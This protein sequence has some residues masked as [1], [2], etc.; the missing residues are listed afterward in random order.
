MNYD[1]GRLTL[2]ILGLCNPLL[3]ITAQVD[4]EFLKKYNLKANDA[5][6]ARDEHLHLCQDMVSSYSVQYTAGGAAQNVM[7]VISGILKR[8]GLK[9]RVMFTGCIGK[10]EY[11]ETMR[12]EAEKDG[13]I[14][15]YSICPNTPTGTCAVCLSNN[16]KNRSLCAFLGA[17]QKFSENHLIENWDELVQNTSVIYISGF[18]LAVSPGIFELLGSHVAT[19]GSDKIFCLNLSAGYIS[20][21]FG[22]RLASVLKY[23]DVVFGNDDEV[24]AYGEYKKWDSNDVEELA[25]RI[26]LDE[27]KRPQVN[28]IVVIT[29]GENP[30]IVVEQLGDKTQVSKFEV[31]RIPDSEVVDTNGAGD[32][33]AGGFVSQYAQNAPLE[34][35]VRTG[36]YAAREIIK[37]PGFVLPEFSE[38]TRS[39]SETK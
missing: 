24:R 1:K 19:S 16:G 36:C 20:S 27:K 33:F 14:T 35:C 5:I 38:I 8:Q 6:L 3:D 30:V 22:D 10:D 34:Q 21:V 29:Q 37:V 13:V 12:K 31:P 28:R 25:T 11:G 9:G 15:N 7:R 17:S 2:T 18:L 39:T 26:C 23:V 4:D 32:A